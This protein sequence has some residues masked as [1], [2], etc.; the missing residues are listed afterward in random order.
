MLIHIDRDA[1][2]VFVA[3]QIKKTIIITHFFLI[4]KNKKNIKL[5]GYEKAITTKITKITNIFDYDSWEI[6]CQHRRKL[7]LPFALYK[8]S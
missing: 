1:D 5:L 3:M 6:T 8:T 4:Y 7:I 2:I